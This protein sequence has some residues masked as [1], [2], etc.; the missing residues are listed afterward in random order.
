VSAAPEAVLWDLDGTI[1]DTEPFFIDAVA[2]LVARAGGA[3]DAED[4]R[5]LVGASLADTAEVARRAGAREA[6][7][8]IVAEVVAAVGER[9]RDGIPWRPGAVD[10]LQRLREAGIPTALVTMSFRSTAEAVLAALPFRG[11]DALVTGEDVEHGKPHP[12]AYLRAADLLGVD[13]TRCVALE[14]SPTGLAAAVAAGAVVVAVPCYVDLPASE[15]YQ[16]WS[17]LVGRDVASVREALCAAV[18]GDAQEDAAGRARPREP[19][20]RGSAAGRTTR[21]G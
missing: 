6:P 2:A 5:R 8:A 3:L 19:R 12:E 14:D 15:G 17:T 11:F 18:D 20:L 16:R 1:V 9:L 13:V 4:R 7:D 10:L 21:A